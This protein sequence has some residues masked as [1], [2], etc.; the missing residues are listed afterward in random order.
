[1][2]DPLQRV[3]GVIASILTLPLVAAL[4][5]AIRLDSPGPFL[6]PGRRLGAGAMPFT[7]FKLRTMIWRQGSRGAG[8]TVGGDARVTRVGRFLRSTRLD[9]LPQLWHVASGRMRFVGP[10]PED[11]RFADLADPLHREVFSAKPGITGLTQ[12]LYV[13][14]ASL[15][16]AADPESQYRSE[17]LPAKLRIDSAYLRHRT[18]R[19]DLWILASTPLAIAGRRPGPPAWLLPPDALARPAGSA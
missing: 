13:D 18:A 5:I 12:L 10:R 2:P 15:L 11:P 14:E 4:A 8:V 19:L 17:I 3:L 6:Y 9:E 7:C 16:T 1:M